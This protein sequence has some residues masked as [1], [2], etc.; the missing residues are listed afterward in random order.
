MSIPWPVEAPLS[1][2]QRVAAQAALNALGFAAG[3]PDGVI[4]T[5]SRAA[6]RR[7][8]AARGLT[9]DGFLTPDLAERLRAEAA[10]VA[11]TGVVQGSSAGR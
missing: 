6:L 7:W 4:G 10:E 11:T 9:A 3:E 5:G 1:R 8:Q 2:E